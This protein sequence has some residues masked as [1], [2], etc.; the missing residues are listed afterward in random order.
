[1][2]SIPYIRNFL[3]VFVYFF[4]THYASSTFMGYM[5]F[6]RITCP[7]H[8]LLL[9][10][11]FSVTGESFKLRLTYSF[12]VVLLYAQINS[13]RIRC[14]LGVR[15]WFSFFLMKT[16]YL[17]GGYRSPLNRCAGSRVALTAGFGDFGWRTRVCG[18]ILA[19]RDTFTLS[20]QDNWLLT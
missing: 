5:I 12:V 15:Y 16:C 18:A 6:M 17:I 11:I 3:A 8:A 7:Y 10:L 1:M 4:V 14:G 19:F 2:Q 20:R 13:I 9:I